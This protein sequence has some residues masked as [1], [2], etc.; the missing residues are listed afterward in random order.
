M[1]KT[2]GDLARER[3][4]TLAVWLT[5]RD[6]PACAYCAFTNEYGDCTRS[7]AN[8]CFDGVLEFLNAPADEERDDEGEAVVD[9][10]EESEGD[11]SEEGEQWTEEKSRKPTRSA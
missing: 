8:D 6:E 11:E 2:V 10:G 3:N 5:D 7:G 4:E 1:S 9:W